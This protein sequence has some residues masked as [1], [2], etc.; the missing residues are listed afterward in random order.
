[1]YRYKII[2]MTHFEEKESYAHKFSKQ[3]LK[4]WIDFGINKYSIGYSKIEYNMPQSDDVL[5]EYPLTK[6][7]NTFAGGQGWG[8]LLYK[9]GPSNGSLHD[10]PMCYIPTYKEC[11]DAGYIP[12]AIIDLVIH[13]KGSIVF[14]IEICN[15]NSV[16]Q[17]K[18][19]KIYKSI[20]GDTPIFEIDSNWIMK[21]FKK[22]E[23]LIFKRQII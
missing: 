5:F 10:D 4:E 17:E 11:A 18:Q 2:E 7:Y 16:S 22:P 15:K 21:Q 20:G 19:D 3:V 14:G 23:K 9:K 6:D 1:M 13:R 12:T 8:H